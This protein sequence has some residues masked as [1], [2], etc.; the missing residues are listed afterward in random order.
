MLTL[1]LLPGRV[2]PAGYHTIHHLNYKTNYGHYFVWFDMLFGTLETP[3]EFEA[4]K[5]AGG[6]KVKAR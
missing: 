5:A 3:E 1:A 6:K 2:R 4:A